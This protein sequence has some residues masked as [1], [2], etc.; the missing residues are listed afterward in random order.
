MQCIYVICLFPSTFA[1]DFATMVVTLFFGGGAAAATIN[2]SEAASVMSDVAASLAVAQCH[3]M[4]SL[5]WSEL[6]LGPVLETRGDVILA[7]RA[8]RRRQQTG[9]P[10]YNRSELEMP[11]VWERFKVF[12]VRPTRMLV[13]EPVVTFFTLWVSFA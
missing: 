3:F 10:I 7:N 6:P 13:T 2:I 4:C 11:G 1:Q 9:R 12:T 5:V 8:K